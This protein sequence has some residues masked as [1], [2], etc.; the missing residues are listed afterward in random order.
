MDRRGVAAAGVLALVMFALAGV[1]SLTSDDRGL[2]LD[3]IP[4]GVSA[5]QFGDTPA[6]LVKR[7][8]K[9]QVFLTDV[10]HLPGER[11]LWW[12]PREGLFAAP[13]HGEL[14]DAEGRV[15]GGPAGAGLNRLA[16][17]VVDGRLVVDRNRV[18]QGKARTASSTAEATPGP[19]PWD[20]GP[21]SFCDG[22]VQAGRVR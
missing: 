20:S 13:T 10:Q 19:G 5:T 3:A 15:I 4:E 8:D 18:I 2:D 1:V 22:A 16:A 6:F 17:R 7:G 21:S 14:F 11:A 12:C 9:V